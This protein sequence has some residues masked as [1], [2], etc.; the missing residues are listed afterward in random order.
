M[1]YLRIFCF[2]IMVILNEGS[3]AQCR[4]TAFQRC[5]LMSV[6]VADDVVAIILLVQSLTTYH[7]V[8]QNICNPTSSAVV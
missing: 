8:L 4:N 7:T 1:K 2:L 3:P 5:F 6:K